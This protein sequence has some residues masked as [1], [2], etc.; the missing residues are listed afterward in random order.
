VLVVEGL[1][2]Q[3]GPVVAVRDLSFRVERGEI[4]TLLGAN[5]AGK[6]TTLAAIMGIVRPSSGRVSFE[7][8]DITGLGPET[9]VRLG[10]TLSPE[11]RRIFAGLTVDENLSLGAASRKDRPAVAR[12]R[13]R[14][15][16]LFPLLRS[17]LAQAA[18][19]LSGGEQQQLAIA[20]ALMC[21]P[22]MLLLDEPSLG[23]A[24]KVVDLVFELV[25]TLRQAFGLTILLVEQNVDRALRISDRGYVLA[26]GALRSSGTSA[27][28]RAS[29]LEREYLG[30][31]A[32]A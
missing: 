30:I 23:L 12:D 19:T 32:E 1:T 16:D 31:G 26:S 10:M 9:I 2:A 11:G 17:R 24:P 21:A 22:R 13:E 28:L 8:R 15:L 29:D 5:G 18:G 14:V 3:Y 27:E 20:R 6:T 25:G 7:G 4:V